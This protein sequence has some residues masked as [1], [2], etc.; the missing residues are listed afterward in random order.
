MEYLKGEQFQDAIEKVIED[1][2]ADGCDDCG[3]NSERFQVE[4]DR[5]VDGEP[6]LVARCGKCSDREKVEALID[7]S[8]A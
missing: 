2:E 1:R 4:L 7:G 5:V 3:D 6:V 8:K